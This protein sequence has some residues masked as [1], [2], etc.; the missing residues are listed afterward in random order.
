MVKKGYKLIVAAYSSPA[1]VYVV[2]EGDK[3]IETISDKHFIHKGVVGLEKVTMKEINEL[4]KANE[5]LG[6]KS[7]PQHIGHKFAA[8]R[9]DCAFPD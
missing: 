9:G 5:Q 8:T 4:K 2:V 1:D 7:E 6:N 3:I